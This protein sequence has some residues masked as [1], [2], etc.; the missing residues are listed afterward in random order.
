MILRGT[1]KKLLLL[2]IIFASFLVVNTNAQAADPN[3]YDF[4]VYATQ[5]IGSSSS[6]YGSDFEGI[7][8]AG[9]SV[10]FTGFSLN[11]TGTYSPSQ[12][13]SLFTGGSVN[14]ASGSVNNG[15]ITAGGNVN[16]NSTTVNGPISSGGNLQGG[17][18]QVNGNVSISGT[19]TS[20]LTINGTVSTGQAY[21][22]SLNLQNVTNYFKSASTFWG[23]LSQTS[24]WAN[25][26]GQ[27]QVAGLQSGRNIVNLNYSDLAG[28]YG[29]KL[30]GS[31][32]AFV[33]FNINGVPSSGANLQ[34]LSLDLSGGITNSDILINLGV[35]NSIT[36]NGG[37]FNILA[38]LTDITY[39]SG[40][41]NGILV[42]QNLN[43]SGQ[44]NRGTFDGFAADQGNFN[45]Q[46]PEPSTYVLLGS[47]LLIGAVAQK[48]RQAII[49]K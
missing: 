27:I 25:S 49:A 29:I 47:M 16:L 15:G 40:A 2:S 30:S 28:V 38:P 22:P 5:N 39:N 20:A 9:G 17:T 42:A 24:S 8:G 11:A 10:Y 3:P 41:L 48:R 45:T 36:I 31:S 43:G 4:N 18:G 44:V 35:A 14:F 26:F 12:P 19:N 33:I 37:S 46:V 23:G 1:M 7:A 34:F 6:Y 21:N 32:D 13:Y